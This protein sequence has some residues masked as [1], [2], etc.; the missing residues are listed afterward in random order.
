MLVS[1]IS[2]TTR[3]YGLL[4][5]ACPVAY[6]TWASEGQSSATVLQCGVVHGKLASVS[7]VK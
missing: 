3:L 6:S 5:T 1:G 4:C 2:M 7:T